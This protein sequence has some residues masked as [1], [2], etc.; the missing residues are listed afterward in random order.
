MCTVTQ[1]VVAVSVNLRKNHL[2]FRNKKWAIELRHLHI[3]HLTRLILPIHLRFLGWVVALF[4]SCLCVSV[5]GMAQTRS[6]PSAAFELYKEAKYDAAA[7][8][9]L[10]DLLVQPWNHELR[11]LVADSLQR[12]GKVAEAKIQ[13]ETLDGTSVAK[14]AKSRLSALEKPALNMVASAPVSPPVVVVTPIVVPVPA[15]ESLPVA[16]LPIQI[17][18][19]APLPVATTVS[20]P[21]LANF[22]IRSPVS[23]PIAM[24]NQSVMM[25]SGGLLQLAPFQYIPPAGAR[26]P[27]Q[28]EQ[29]KRSREHQRL[30]DLNAEG[31]YQA[32]G[33]EGL[34]LQEK[35]GMDDE[36]KLIFANSLAWTGRLPEAK[37]TYQGLT[38]GRLAKEAN[39]GL[40]NIDRWLG[41][42]HRAAPVYRSVLAMDPEN[43]DAL[44][45]LELT[46][47]ELS[48][49]TM[50]TYGGSSD[51]SDLYTRAFTANH[52]WRDSTGANVM[53]VETSRFKGTF[54]TVEVEQKDATFRYRALEREYKPS[55]EISTIGNA[56][57]GGAGV[58]LGE[59]PVLV[60][61]GLV[62][63]GRF[64]SNPN[65]LAANLSA[66][67]LGL[68]VPHSFS[69]GKLVGRVDAYGISDGNTILTSS[70][71]LSPLWRPLGSHFK[72]LLSIDTRKAKFNTTNYWSPV[73]VSG[74]LGAGLL[75][76]WGSDNWNLYASGQLG[77][78]L[79][80]ET[81]DSWSWTAGGK[82][83]LTDD[84][85]I[86]L[87]LWSMLGQRDNA[88]YRA[89]SFS[90]N[91]EKL[92][93]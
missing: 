74:S 43:P 84:I 9:G 12:I 76:E 32:V 35:G 4:V 53:E 90:I 67:H 51:S 29:P 17:W 23:I 85:A 91:L 61:V 60:E 56:V 50:L 58:S 24:S 87:N 55:F 64:T 15:A 59:R 83:W 52:R 18:A 63:W 47:R 31:D 40:A 39:I 8:R 44:L 68:Q 11:L 49:R 2:H 79:Y 34:A 77:R 41:Y 25:P 19:P 72:P 88:T 75:G 82:R 73:Q 62:N 26:L 7:A 70:L 66:S 10:S 28:A 6:Q 22:P 30:V 80:G 21:A 5:P 37:Q 16:I 27:E 42:D 38:T 93:R 54:P 33:T 48:P 3:T 36:L 57:Y 45:G 65:A 92:W 1:S 86:S 78:P 20:T 46:S 89:N 81:G 13:L 14:E 71:R 69:F